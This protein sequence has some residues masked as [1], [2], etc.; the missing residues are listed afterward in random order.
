MLKH[1]QEPNYGS[2]YPNDAVVMA[3]KMCDIIILS[4]IF[5]Q[6][7][8]LGSSR[9]YIVVSVRTSLFDTRQKAV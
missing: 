3:K 1:V 6:I 4:P 8:K 5:L 9:D 7:A 2:V